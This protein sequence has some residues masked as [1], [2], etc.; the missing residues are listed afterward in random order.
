[1]YGGSI[2]LAVVAVVFTAATAKT[3]LGELSDEQHERFLQDIKIMEGRRQDC[4]TSVPAFDCGGNACIA[5]F[6]GCYH[7][8][9][10]D[11]V[12]PKS[13]LVNLRGTIDWQKWTTAGNAADLIIRCAKLAVQKNKQYFGVEFYGECYF[14][15][16]PDQSQ[17]KV[18]VQDGCDKFCAYDVGGAN[19]IVLYRVI[20][21]PSG[22]S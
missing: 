1:M 5:F 7:N 9:G 21:P 13:S 4:R 15:D 20:T 3:N 18:T 16:S 22:Q 17:P 8:T 6:D 2:I 14:G 10:P 11:Y 19:A 12:L